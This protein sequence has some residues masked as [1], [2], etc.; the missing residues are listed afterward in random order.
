MQ[1]R[2]YESLTSKV[3]S[4]DVADLKALYTKGKSGFMK[5]GIIFLII[6]SFMSP[7]LI[8]ATQM[9]IDAIIPV[10]LQV[11]FMAV[12][13]IIVGV[14]LIQ[15]QT[16]KWQQ[17]VRLYRFAQANNLK[18]NPT[19]NNPVRDGII[20]SI[21]HSRNAYNILTSA[22]SNPFEIANYTYT[23][24]SG[25]NS[26]TYIFGYIM[27]QLDRNLP[28]MVLDSKANNTNILGMSFSGL[29][30]EFDKDQKL[31]LEGDFDSHFTLYAPK[32]YEKDALYIFTPDLMQLFID[33]SLSFDAEIIDNK[34]FIYSKQQFNLTDPALLQRLFNVIDTVAAKVDSRADHYIDERVGS[35]IRD[36][37]AEPGRRLKIRKSWIVIVVML[38]YAIYFVFSILYPMLSI[39]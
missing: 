34:I 28:H 29:P 18:F 33:E 38:L 30:V 26:H 22:S 36:I 20:F 10:L 25:K 7:V 39:K 32:E 14:F 2:N 31:S 35:A 6:L 27:V 15:Q 11:G 21:G 12:V 24:G 4:R 19:I 5:K 37:V 16:K 13:A 8:F 3:T 23:T 17:G 1:N 9:N